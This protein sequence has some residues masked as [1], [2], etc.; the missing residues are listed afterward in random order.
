M[1]KGPVVGISFWCL[2]SSFRDGE[3]AESR[4]EWTAWGGVGFYFRR[5]F[6]HSPLCPMGP[7][8]FQGVPWILDCLSQLH[9]GC[10][11][12][13]PENLPPLGIG[14]PIAADTGVLGTQGG[15]CSQAHQR[16]PFVELYHICCC[17]KHLGL[18]S[19]WEHKSGNWDLVFHTPSAM[20]N[21]PRLEAADLGSR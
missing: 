5:I 4:G 21:S 1:G 2:S 8:L 13:E 16:Q 11:L 7:S 19:V 12:S 17:K 14:F 20:G 18:F 10:H 9:P 6:G 3:V 15:L